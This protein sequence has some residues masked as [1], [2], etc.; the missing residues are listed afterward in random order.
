MSRL[1]E[2]RVRELYAGALRLVAERGYESVTMDHIAEATRSSKATLYRQ[3]GS[4]LTLFVEALTS[5]S[6][7][8]ETAPDTGSLRGD[9]CEMFAQED[10]KNLDRPPELVGAILQAMKQNEELAAAVRTQIIDP[11]HERINLFVQR[12][13]D[14]G[15]LGADCPAIPHLHLALLAPFVLSATLTGAE[16]TP[17]DVL[18]YIDGLVLPALGIH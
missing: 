6:P 11:V 12:A 4:K 13:V 2:D 16:Y 15:E 18:D 1:S 3:W 9:L 10:E 14:R 17:A 7:V 8:P 5:G